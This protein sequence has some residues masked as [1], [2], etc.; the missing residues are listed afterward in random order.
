MDKGG[1][2][3]SPILAR[4]AVKSLVETEVKTGDGGDAVRRR[5]PA[6]FRALVE[7]CLLV[8]E[9]LEFTTE[10]GR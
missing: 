2:I 10:A 5:L 3:A 1:K 8:M 7:M 4:K 9:L 6:G